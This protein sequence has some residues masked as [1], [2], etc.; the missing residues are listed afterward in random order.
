MN[1]KLIYTIMIAILFSVS[2]GM[3]NYNLDAWKLPATINVRIQKDNQDNIWRVRGNEG[4][5]MGTINANKSTR[6]QINWQIIGSDMVFSFDKDVNKYFEF[7][8]GLFEDGYTQRVEA[9]KMIRLTV[10]EDAPSDTL[11]YNVFV[12]AAEK[13]VVGNS[14]PKVIIR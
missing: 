9:N 1:K 3:V 4:N 5:N 13:Y 2:A 6:D 12:I 14:P 8:E 7:E 11:I 10:R